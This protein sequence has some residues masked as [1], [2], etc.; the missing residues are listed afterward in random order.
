MKKRNIRQKI[1]LNSGMK[2]NIKIGAN[3]QMHDK[4]QSLIVPGG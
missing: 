1:A 3:S 2:K 4:S